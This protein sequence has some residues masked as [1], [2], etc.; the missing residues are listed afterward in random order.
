MH[1][2]YG[3]VDF[4]L[5]RFSLSSRARPAAA[6]GAVRAGAS[7]GR[8][9][10]SAALAASMRPAA[11]VGSM[12]SGVSRGMMRPSA[13]LGTMVSG[14]S[15]GRMRPAA[16][17]GAMQTGVSLGPMHR[18]RAM[19]Q[20]SGMARAVSP[21]ARGPMVGMAR[22][23]S[24][25]SGIAT[26]RMSAISRPQ[27]VDLSLDQFELSE[28]TRVAPEAASGSWSCS[29]PAPE[30]CIDISKAFWESLGDETS[31]VFKQDDRSLLKA[32]FNPNLS[33]RRLDGELFV[34]P[35]TTFSHVQRLASLVKAEETVQGERKTHFLSARF[36]V[37]DAGPLFPASWTC[38]FGIANGQASKNSQARP[39][40]ACTEY[41][42]QANVLEQAMGT[43][44]PTFD[45]STEDGMR[46]R[47]YN[48]GSLDVRT[49]QTYDGKEAVGVVFSTT[50]APPSTSCGRLS[51]DAVEH[52]KIVKVS[53][54]V[55]SSDVEGL[56]SSRRNYIVLQTQSGRSIVTERLWMVDRPGMKHLWH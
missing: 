36:A 53:E 11:A 40:R 35:E 23:M 8:M 54:Y 50:P 5:D 56:P 14:V 25:V 51:G 34:P 20:L 33:D 42:A 15:M 10:P 47:I 12:L 55:E 21:V 6:I 49:T 27:G 17:I 1:G 39:L 19:T 7:F 4:G 18:Q 48:F 31:E 32:I 41:M 45:K 37:G 38:S 52:E 24:L 22:S 9:R 13:A 46:F 44:I 2:V 3:G 16:A 30:A 29:M 43:A 28:H 26:T